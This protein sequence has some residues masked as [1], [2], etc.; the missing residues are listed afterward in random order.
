[1]AKLK[2]KLTVGNWLNVDLER[3]SS[4]SNTLVH[5]IKSTYR[6]HVFSSDRNSMKSARS[7]LSF[8]LYSYF[9]EDFYCFKEKSFRNRCKVFITTLKYFSSCYRSM[10]FSKQLHFGDRLYFLGFILKFLIVFLRN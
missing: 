2:K 1:M 6:F 7:F 4:P 3:V 10:Q 8:F 9:L 5:S